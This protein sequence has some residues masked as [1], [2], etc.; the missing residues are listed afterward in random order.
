MARRERADRLAL[1][2]AP[3]I[4]GNAPDVSGGAAGTGTDPNAGFAGGGGA[5]GGNGGQAG[6]SSGSAAAGSIGLSV[7]RTT[8]DPVPLFLGS[9]HL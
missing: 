1:R 2:A 7:S 6:G 3:S 4:T 9:A 5:C 8:A